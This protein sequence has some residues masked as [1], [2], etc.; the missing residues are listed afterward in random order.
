M[1][2]FAFGVRVYPNAE[3]TLSHPLRM[4]GEMEARAFVDEQIE[5][6]GLLRV[7]TENSIWFVT[8]ERYQRL[9][10][11][12][13]PRPAVRSIERRL[14]DGEWH[15]LRRSWWRVHHDGARQMRLLPEVGPADGVG[16]ITG[17]IVAVGGSWTAVVSESSSA[18]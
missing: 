18:Q 3:R 7:E 4:F 14:A 10:R 11:E 13:R 9:P 5:P 8:S 6:I 15:G 17:V 1:G 12:E 2:N 16:V